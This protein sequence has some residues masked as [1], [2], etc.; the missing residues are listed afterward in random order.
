MQVRQVRYF[1][2]LILRLFF[3]V[4]VF[5]ALSAGAQDALGPTLGKISAQGRVYLGYREA[6]PPFTYVLPGGTQPTGYVWDICLHVV[7]ALEARVGKPLEVV[8]VVVSDN[9]RPMLIKNNV[10][11]LDCGG[12]A[13]TVARQKQVALSVTLYVSDV[14]VLVR[15]DSGL[16]MPADLAGKRIVTVSGG[17][18]RQL[19]R[20]ALEKNI[21]MQH[22]LAN[23][24]A[25]AMTLLREGRT[26]GI[27][28]EDAT[29]S[30]LRA[31]K[32]EFRLLD[33][34]LA[35]EPLALMFP[36]GDA[37]FKALVDETLIGLM[38]RGEMTAIYDKWFMSP[39]PSESVSLDLPM[40]QALK[41]AILTPSDTPV[42]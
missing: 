3:V 4:G 1:Y 27:V 7:K 21:S 11:D 39:L 33:V 18:E 17:S 20:M 42:N 13:N 30:I 12:A 36:L 22:Q 37:S 35:T 14:K 16:A 8:P 29:L 6:M 26:D 10:V 32:A 40:S 19:K 23:S 34:V 15:S 28:A 41:A 38:K 2:P 24:P 5:F 31:G 25:D 9:A